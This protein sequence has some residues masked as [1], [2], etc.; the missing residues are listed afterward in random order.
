MANTKN[1][2]AKTLALIAA[3]FIA[4]GDDEEEALQKANALYLK[5]T[6]YAKKFASLEADE[7]EFEAFSDEA[8]RALG[9]REDLAIG[10]SEA[11]S[12]ALK[13]FRE[14]AKTKLDRA[15]THKSLLKIIEREFDRRPDKSTRYVPEKIAKGVL[16]G[17]H[18]VL[19]ADRSRARSKRFRKK[20][21]KKNRRAG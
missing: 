4:R 12:P 13:Y 2:D 9:E 7:K 5:A 19:R 8:V 10:D 18:T 17:L 6:A 20:S 14:T 11:N 3:H 21:V 16:D 15:I 1:C